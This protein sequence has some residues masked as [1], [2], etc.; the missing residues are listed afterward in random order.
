LQTSIDNLDNCVDV[1]KLKP[2]HLWCGRSW[3]LV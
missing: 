1:H 3:G 2:H